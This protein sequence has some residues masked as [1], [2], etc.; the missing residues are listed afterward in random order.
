MP[1]GQREGLHRNGFLIEFHIVCI[2]STPF[3]I[4]V[5]IK[6]VRIATGDACVLCFI[7]Y[8]NFK[9]PSLRLELRRHHTF[10]MA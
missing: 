10:E 6:F 2:N 7:S 8:G 1:Y 5:S 4:A 9:L 3:R